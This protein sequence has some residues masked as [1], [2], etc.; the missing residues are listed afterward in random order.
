MQ[1]GADGMVGVLVPFVIG[2]GDSAAFGARAFA[3]V[4]GQLHLRPID[5]GIRSLRYGR[6][7]VDPFPDFVGIPGLVHRHA[8][9]DGHIV[10]YVLVG[11]GALVA[12]DVVF[13]ARAIVVTGA[14]G[15]I[16][17]RFCRAA[18]LIAAFFFSTDLDLIV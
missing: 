15:M 4:I 8:L 3:L 11:A 18:F 16:V 17:D 1:I 5:F 13:I 14:F 6:L 10:A 2:E 12:V 9:V 7:D